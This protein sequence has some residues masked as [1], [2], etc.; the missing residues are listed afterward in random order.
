MGEP[1]PKPHYLLEKASALVNCQYLS[2]VTFL[3]SEEKIYAHKLLLSLG[4][5]VF[6]RMFEDDS[7]STGRR[8]IEV[9]DLSPSIFLIMIK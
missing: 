1:S 9:P 3:L 8:L 6:R 7:P 5:P 2:D 4:S